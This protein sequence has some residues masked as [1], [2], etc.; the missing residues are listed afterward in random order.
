MAPFRLGPTPVRVAVALLALASVLAACSRP[1]P[2]PAPTPAGP[3]SSG[4]SPSI[5]SPAR[6]ALPGFVVLG[7]VDPRI[8]TDIRYATPHNFVGRPITAY[9]EPL[10]LLTR[11]AAE[12]LRRVEDAALAGG[13]TLKVYD[14]YRPVPAVDDFVDWAKRPGEQQTKAEFY[15][16]LAKSRLF[17]DG[18]IGAPTAHSRGS[19]LDLTLVA[20]PA[21]TQPAYVPGQPLAACTAPRADRFPDNSVDMGTGFDCFDSLAHTADPRVTGPARDNRMLLKRLMTDAGFVNY[22]REWWHYSYRDEP[23]PDTFFDAPVARSSVG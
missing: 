6:P 2:R 21:A 17:A 13:H 10:C 18:Y 22:D 5:S 11:R 8:L 14:C 23:Y 12:A 15:P 1:E 4:P 16:H 9:R 3:T 20:V 19:T 7:D